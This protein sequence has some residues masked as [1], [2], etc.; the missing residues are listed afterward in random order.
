MATEPKSAAQQVVEDYNHILTNIPINI[1]IA[2]RNWLEAHFHPL[3]ARYHFMLYVVQATNQRADFGFLDASSNAQLYDYL[4]D[5]GGGGV[6]LLKDRRDERDCLNLLTDQFAR[7]ARPI[8]HH[9]NWIRALID[10]AV[11]SQGETVN[12]SKLKKQALASKLAET[13]YEMHITGD[14]GNILPE[15]WRYVMG[16]F[17]KGSSIMQHLDGFVKGI[18]VDLFNGRASGELA[19]S[20]ILLKHDPFS[21]SSWSDIQVQSLDGEKGFLDPLPLDLRRPLHSLLFFNDINGCVSRVL[22]PEVLQLKGDGEVA[23]VVQQAWHKWHEGEVT[24]PD[25]QYG[26]VLS[27][28]PK[29]NIVELQ[30]YKSFALLAEKYERFKAAERTTTTR[31]VV[32]RPRA[33]EG[34]TEVQQIQPAA[35]KRKAK[36]IIRPPAEGGVLEEKEESKGM[37]GILVILGVLVGG[38]VAF[39]KK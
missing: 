23:N 7:F 25:G 13:L 5:Y 39:G 9:V 21:D 2:L 1:D 4:N 20:G 22:T 18:D 31:D 29:F 12:Q 37:F 6:L 24:I 17:G 26:S 19:Q 35:K 14:E 30:A 36:V 34:I 11:D 10:F 8:S 27:S 32:K 28:E 38:Y 15:H 16:L 33:V 3:I